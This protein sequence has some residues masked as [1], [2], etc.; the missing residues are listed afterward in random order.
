MIKKHCFSFI[1]NIFFRVVDKI[2]AHLTSD[3]IL[4]SVKYPSVHEV[5]LIY[6]PEAVCQHLNN[7]VMNLHS[8][9]SSFIF[10]SPLS[11]A[12]SAEPSTITLYQRV[13]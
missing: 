4:D 9:G 6:N 13:G 2:E 10:E 8:R 11:E 12:H 5:V 3:G 7:L 1:G